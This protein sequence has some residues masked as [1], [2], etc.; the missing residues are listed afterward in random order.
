ME[1]RLTV[2]PA[3]RVPQEISIPEVTIA[4]HPATVTW[5]RRKRGLF[6]RWSVTYVTVKFH[7]PR[8]ERRLKLEFSGRVSDDAF[9]EMIEASRYVRCH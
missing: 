1:V 9:Q 8:T 7:C 4:G 5:Q 2:Q 6:K 3:R